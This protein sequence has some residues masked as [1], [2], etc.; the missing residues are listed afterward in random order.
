MKRILLAVSLLSSLALGCSTRT[1]VPAVTTAEV[2]AAPARIVS[3]LPVATEELEH[4]RQVGDFVVYR[5]SG[6]YRD[7]PVEVT[8]TVVGHDA[9][10]LVIDVTVDERGAQERLRMRLHP[11]GSLASVARWEG[12]VLRPFGVAAYENLMAE[13]TLAA[14]ENLGLIEEQARPIDI[15]GETIAATTS[16]YRVRVGAHDAVLVTKHAPDFRW[17]DVGGEIRTVEGKVLYRAEIVEAGSTAANLAAQEEDG[18]LLEGLD[19]LDEI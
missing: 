15:A 3:A 10:M 1:M 9:E 14:D 6:S 7:A 4:A 8:H 16:R 11:S 5:F 18:D 12:K 17:G 13:L 19:Y 2:E